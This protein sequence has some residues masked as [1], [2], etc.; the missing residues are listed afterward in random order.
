M[1][2]FV[3]VSGGFDPLHQGH[4]AYLEAAYR[5][6]DGLIVGFNRDERIERK[7]GKGLLPFPDREAVLNE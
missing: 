4:L 2:K 3:L 7:K 5:L 6:G 1:K